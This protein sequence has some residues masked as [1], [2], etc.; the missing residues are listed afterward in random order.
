MLLGPKPAPTRSETT[1]TALP[2]P[3]ITIKR[4]INRHRLSTS[5]YLAS[6]LANTPEHAFLLPKVA[7]KNKVMAGDS[8]WVAEDCCVKTTPAGIPGTFDAAL[9][10]LDCQQQMVRGVSQSDVRGFPLGYEF[11]IPSHRMREW[12]HRTELLVMKF[13]VYRIQQIPDEHPA[14]MGAIPYIKD[15][16][17]ITAIDGHD[18][19]KHNIK[20]CGKI[21]MRQWMLRA[22]WDSEYPQLELKW[23]KNPLVV[24]LL[25]STTLN[26]CQQQQRRLRS[27]IVG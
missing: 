17:N 27:A 24:A 12:M 1:L 20:D 6:T 18:R 10:Y 7:L 5:P 4:R 14:V 16:L 26:K 11:A 8:I 21:T 2:S 9:T 15:E 13:Q 19:R 3:P 22:F 23:G 25:V